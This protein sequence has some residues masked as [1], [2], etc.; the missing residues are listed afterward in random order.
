MSLVIAIA[1]GVGMMYLIGWIFYKAKS[2][3]TDGTTKIVDAVNCTGTV[4]L[5]FKNDE[6][7]TVHIDVNG[8]TREYD[9]MAVDDKDAFKVGDSVMVSSIQG[10]FVKVK[11]NN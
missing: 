11:K 6:V 9:A 8:I 4:Y 1:I 2:L 10:N 3:E 5:P 7:G